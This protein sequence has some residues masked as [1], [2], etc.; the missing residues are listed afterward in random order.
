MTPDTTDTIAAI[1]T[2]P[3]QGGIGV[4]RISG[5]DVPALATALLGALP[6][7]RRAEVHPFCAAD[8]EMIDEGLVLYFA[9]P[10]SFTGEHVLELQGHGGPVVMQL[11][12]AR[13]LELGARPARPGEFSERAFLNHKLD[14]T[15]AEAIADLIESSTA[16][17][18]R[19]AMQ[20]LQGVFSARVHA[21]T[22]SL[23]GLRMYVEAAID[24]PE[25]EIDFLSDKKVQQDLDRVQQDLADVLQIAQQGCLLRDGLRLVIAGQPNAGKSSLLNRLAE[26]EA[27]IVSDIPGTTRDVVRE[28]IQIDGM[29]LQILDTAGLRD[30]DDRVE[31]EG[32]RRT[33]AEMEQAD[34]VLYLID[35]QQAD[36]LPGSDDL[37]TDL[38]FTLV[39]NKIDLSGRAEGWVEDAVS[40]TIGISV[41][42]GQG[43]EA[44]KAHLK[45]CAGFTEISEGGFSARRRHLDALQRALAHIETGAR[46]L[47]ESR[48]GELL[49]EE[50]RLAQ[51]ALGEITGEITPDDLLGQIFSSFCI[52]K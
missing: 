34:H 25:E 9:A 32:M 29:P 4:V 28:H 26:R 49:A 10:A 7:P 23:T 36:G 33:R 41:K 38:A 12:L 2:P 8:G 13:V 52:G 47:N 30:S 45:R 15:Q 48:A 3:G 46:Q 21:L 6:E 35:D 5:P 40:P 1:A 22:D 31:Q 16:S 20:S 50:L 42:T 24:F 18:A 44:L 43:L 14:L 11:L 17:A 37:P 19:A 27:A 39:L 51:N